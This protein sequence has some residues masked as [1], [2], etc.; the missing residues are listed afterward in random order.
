MAGVQQGDPLA[1]LLFCLT[2]LPHTTNINHLCPDLTLN[3]WSTDDGTFIGTPE[4]IL[5]VTNYFI[6]HGPA[7]GLFLNL[8]KCEIF[9]LSPDM[10]TQL[11]ILPP[12][13]LRCSHGMSILGSAIG[14][15]HY[16]NT[17]VQHRVD[18]ISQYIAATDLVTN[19][20][21]KFILVRSCVGLPKFSYVLRTT[22]PDTIASAIKNFDNLLFHVA[23]S[24]V[25]NTP[26]GQS[27]YTRMSL[28]IH[29]GGCGLTQANTISPCAYSASRIQSLPLQL[30]L[31][32]I[33]NP[34]ESS[35]LFQHYRDYHDSYQTIFPSK[36]QLTFQSLRTSRNPQQLLQRKLYDH[37]SEL[38]FSQ[39][40]DHRSKC[41]IRCCS[42]MSG[43]W[44]NVLPNSGFG[45]ELPDADFRCAIRYRLGI[46]LYAAPST[47]P[48]C[49]GLL[50]TFGDHTI[51]C[52]QSGDIHTR[53][54]SLKRVLRDAATYAH[55]QIPHYEPVGLIPS[56]PQVR[57]ADLFF[58]HYLQNKD[59]CVDVTCI[60]SF[61]YSNDIGRD[62]VPE[63]AMNFSDN[64][65]FDKYLHAC[66]TAGYSFLPFSVGTLGGFSASALKLIDWLAEKQ[67]NV[68]RGVKTHYINWMKQRIQFTI[69]QQQGA[70]WL[71]KGVANNVL[72][73]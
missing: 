13:M 29:Y 3:V 36:H 18:K 5:T 59:L 23:Q 53:H 10:D 45:F 48:D 62:F 65:K 71:R 72:L 32:H 20:H 60:D 54:E 68:H 50:D 39:I 27:E 63:E 66:D 35:F 56:D 7:S 34:I 73:F 69:Q 43:L 46:P 15:A 26:I 14:S 11:S 42:W 33:S 22:H 52:G 41:L 9:P 67:H 47:C 6:E 31:L 44:L 24:L 16:I 64:H 58:P 40:L 30:Q 57:P 37:T 38:L 8:N 25:G 28:P 51:I 17:Q 70:A 19:L 1:S 21:L 2:L 61:H 4:E 55:L 49:K 12:T